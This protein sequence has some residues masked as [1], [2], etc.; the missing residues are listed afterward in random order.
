M[1]MIR[2]VIIWRPAESSL[3][4]VFVRSKIDTP[5]F[6]GL[7]DIIHFMTPL[8]LV[9]YN[10]LPSPVLVKKKAT[11]RLPAMNILDRP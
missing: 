9:Y 1:V 6:C 4:F 3:A 11:K 10:I 5:H 8:P 7:Q 2:K